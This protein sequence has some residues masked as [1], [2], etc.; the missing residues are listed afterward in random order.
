MGT[1]Y[2]K[3]RPSARS[4]HHRRRKQADP[5]CV[6]LFALLALL[7]AGVGFLIYLYKSGRILF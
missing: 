1:R 4:A 2:K 5:V 7:L 3:H 6:L